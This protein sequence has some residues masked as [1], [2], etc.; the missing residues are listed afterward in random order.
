[1]TETE[2][3]FRGTLKDLKAKGEAP[4]VSIELKLEFPFN[5]A[6]HDGWPLDLSQ[7]TTLLG[8]R[9]AVKLSRADGGLPLFPE[10]TS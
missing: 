1:M 4:E 9:V 7:L 6:D 10:E 8:R 5:Q 2:F 3:S